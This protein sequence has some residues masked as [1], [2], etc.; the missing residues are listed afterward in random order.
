MLKIENVFVKD[1]VMEMDIEA[2]IYWWMDFD[3]TNLAIDCEEGKIG[4]K[5]FTINDFSYNYSAY[6]PSIFL[7]TADTIDILNSIRHEYKL[8]NDPK[9]KKAKLLEIVQLLPLSYTWKKLVKVDINKAVQ[10]AES[11]RGSNYFEWE[12]F[13]IFLKNEIIRHIQT[14]IPIRK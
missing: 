2:P 13:E 4:E 6:N 1:N 7:R 3:S 10:V 11:K 8:A 5:D 12:L 9:I 14:E